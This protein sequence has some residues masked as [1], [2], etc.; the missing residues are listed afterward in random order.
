MA[1]HHANAVH[2]AILPAQQA[3]RRV[4]I[5]PHQVQFRVRWRG[6]VVLAFAQDFGYAAADKAAAAEDENVHFASFLIVADW[7][8]GLGRFLRTPKAA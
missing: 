3:L 4:Q 1:A 2:H 8:V 7:I 5:Q 6:Y